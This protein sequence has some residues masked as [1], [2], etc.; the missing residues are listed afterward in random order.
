M[1]RVVS[2]LVLLSAL[3]LPLSACK[4]AETL[5]RT[6]LEDGKT[7][8][9]SLKFWMKNRGLVGNALLDNVHFDDGANKRAVLTY[10]KAL[11]PAVDKLKQGTLYKVTYTFKKAADE[12]NLGVLTKVE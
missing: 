12:L 3:A 1:S 5:D 7:Y 6:K 2:S 9:S 8:T 4:K 10:D 11:A